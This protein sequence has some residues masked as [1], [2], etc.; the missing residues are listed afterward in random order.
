VVGAAAAVWLITV[1]SRRHRLAVDYRPN[2]GPAHE[3]RK[4]A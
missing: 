3:T 2:P 4:P 1:V